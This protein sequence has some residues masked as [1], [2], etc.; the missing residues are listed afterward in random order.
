MTRS[1]GPV[2]VLN[3]ATSEVERVHCN[4]CIF[5]DHRDLVHVCTHV[6]RKNPR[7]LN[8]SETPD[9]CEMK[10]SA[11][12]DAQDMNRG[13]THYVMRWSG[14]KSDDPRE[15]WKGIPSEALRQFRLAARDAKRGTVN[16]ED[17]AGTVLARWPEVA[18]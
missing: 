14:R 9:W 15:I 8:P 6:D 13:V 4:F 17:G 2:V 12:Q 7:T 3:P 1:F 10:A 5:R 11:I 16:L 18:A